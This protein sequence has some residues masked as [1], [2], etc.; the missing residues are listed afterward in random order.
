MSSGP[1]SRRPR[2]RVAQPT[3]YY[4]PQPGFYGHIDEDGNYSERP[5]EPEA[6][7]QE[8]QQPTPPPPSNLGPGR[9]RAQPPPALPPATVAP[10]SPSYPIVFRAGRV[11]ARQEPLTAQHACEFVRLTRA[12]G[13]RRPYL[14]QADRLALART[15][16]IDAREVKRETGQVLHCDFLADELV[17]AFALVLGTG[18]DSLPCDPH[19]EPDRLRR[20][21][22]A[23]LRWKHPAPSDI[24]RLAQRLTDLNALR[25]LL[26]GAGTTLAACRSS[27][28]HKCFDSKALKRLEQLL[29][30]LGLVPD[31]QDSGSATAGSGAGLDARLAAADAREFNQLCLLYPLT[32]AL[33]YRSR[34]DTLEGFL[35]DARDGNLPAVPSL[36]RAL[37]SR[38]TRPRNGDRPVGEC[39][40]SVAAVLRRRELGLPTNPM[41]PM[42]EMNE[43]ALRPWKSW[44]GASNDIEHVA[45]SPDGTRFVVGAAAHSDV[46]NRDRN[47][48]LGDLLSGRLRELPDHR[49]AHTATTQTATSNYRYTSIT[50]TL[51]RGD[52]MYTSSFDHTVKV[53]D[54]SSFETT[55][56]IRTLP[57]ESNV[58]SV[59]VCPTTGVIYSAQSSETAPFLGWSPRGSVPWQ[60]PL[61]NGCGATPGKNMVTSALSIGSNACSQWLC[62][63]LSG[64]ELEGR[65]DPSKDGRLLFWK[66]AEAGPVLEYT[67]VMNVF[68]A[69]WHP[70]LALIAVGSGLTQS[71]SGRGRDVRSM[72][73]LYEPN[74]HSLPITEYLCPGLDIN[75]VSF[76]PTNKHYLS[77][78]CTDGVTYVFDHRSPAAPVHSLVHGDP[79]SPV[80]A[81]SQDG[82][83]REQGDVGVRFVAW[84]TTDELYTGST[85]GVVKKWDILRSPEDVLVEDVLSL[86]V[87]ISCGQFS[88][89]YTHLLLGDATGAIHVY[90]SAPVADI[91]FDSSDCDGEVD[92]V[93]S[94]EDTDTDENQHK[95]GGSKKR[96]F[97]FESAAPPGAVADS[98]PTSDAESGV[99]LARQF[100]ASGELVRNDVIGVVQGPA[101]GE[102]PLTRNLVAAWARPSDVPRE[103]LLA[104]PL[105]PEVRA[106]Q[107]LSPDYTQLTADDRRLI[108]Q[109]VRLGVSRNRMSGERKRRMSDDAADLRPEVVRRHGQSMSPPPPPQQQRQVFQPMTPSTAAATAAE[110]AE[111]QPDQCLSD[112]LP[113]GLPVIVI[114]DDEDEGD[115]GNGT[116]R[117]TGSTAREPV[118]LLYHRCEM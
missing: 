48:V 33:K 118:L 23:T 117:S 105:L 91:P 79:I 101:Y 37:R 89:D 75:E 62:G 63:G 11:Y 96:R 115:E 97:I 38:V 95:D 50:Q 85:D 45:W 54:A 56:C 6:Q 16:G 80:W 61:W 36:I 66:F 42:G 70:H 5:I 39:D 90:A 34:P 93:S 60:L 107:L 10:R 69:K 78:S 55:R 29:T 44:K 53:W 19:R 22:A 20:H 1:G 68:D 18:V 31:S 104:T 111:A 57:H 109:Q 17:A 102:G 26:S 25:K 81:N 30:K 4:A 27:F 103:A 59:D 113:H 65:W 76:C 13:L 64:T 14:C 41:A 98:S 73:R 47:L 71:D 100:L 92:R 46:Y 28:P 7:A 9:R 110:L 88:P 2:R 12:S 58:N 106:R 15:G 49:L 112:G 43:L 51:W 74:T 35:K 87:E 94:G 8:D 82:A 99:A 52:R 114:S 83:T 21:F 72:V 67:R 108:D 116:A 84:R 32:K 77:A 40:R 86:N 3:N 24:K